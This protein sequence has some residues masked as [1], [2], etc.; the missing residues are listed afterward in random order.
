MSDAALAAFRQE[1]ERAVR[2]LLDQPLR[3][4]TLVHHNDTDGI[5][6]GAVLAT[7]LERAGFAVER[8][9][10]ERVHP[11]FLPRI[12][13][14]SR[15]VVLYADLGSQS[16]GLIARAATPGSRVLV[17]DH[18]V[19]IMPSFDL[20]ESVALLNP[21]RCGLD[22][23]RLASAATVAFFLAR[24]VSAAN[25][26][27][28]YLAV[29]GAAGDH[30]VTDGEYAG[31]NREAF[32][33][34]VRRG[35]IQRRPGAAVA[36]VFPLFGSVTA[37]DVSRVVLELA[38]AG[39]HQGG[40]EA[41][42]DFC[43]R[44]PSESTQRFAAGLRE[45]QAQRFRE[46]LG[47][48]ERDGIERRG[49]VQWVDTAGRLHPLGLKAIGLLCQELSAGPLAAPD[50]YLAGFQDFPREFP[51]LGAFELDETKVSFRVPPALRAAIERGGRPHL[52]DIV[53]AAAREAGGH[54]EGCHRFSA[55]CSIPRANRDLLLAAVNRCARAGITS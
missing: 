52:A 24:S 15:R 20:P 5:A 2:F 17:V 12:H 21:E 27:L 41:A 26:D 25:E 51:H 42:L 8:I 33:I 6:A 13:T 48:V 53:P 23:D 47:R 28:A 45:L 7:A 37:P 9:P 36:G 18:H 49:R 30:Q 22:G 10:I 16:L 44:G 50:C 39:Y 31:L 38:V 46:E 14:P 19:P 40:A 11:M 35:A 43:L 32:E 34:G 4:V 29:I 1:R 54:A 3:A 55:A